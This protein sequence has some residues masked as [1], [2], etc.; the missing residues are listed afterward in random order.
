M[1]EPKNPEAAEPVQTTD[2]QAVD[3]AATCSAERDTKTVSRW[4]WWIASLAM[5]RPYPRRE[6]QVGDTVV[7]VTH[8]IGLA[9][10]RLGLHQAIGELLEIRRGKFG[11]E[12][13]IKSA[14]P[15]EGETWWENARIEVIEPNAKLSDEPDNNQKG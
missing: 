4:V 12:Y 7:E 8:L 14:D 1:N 6:P 2:D 15:A 9:R 11:P 5:E 13:L 3:P 10:H